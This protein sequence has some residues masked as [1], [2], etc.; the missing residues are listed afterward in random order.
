MES[1][2]YA[3]CLITGISLIANILI[4]GHMIK[5]YTEYFKDR[6]ISSRGKESRERNRINNDG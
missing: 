3:V 4:L 1:A 5:L 2:L 6:S